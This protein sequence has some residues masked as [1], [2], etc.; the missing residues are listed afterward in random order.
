M[1]L[2]R[3]IFL[4]KSPKES[5]RQVLENLEKRFEH[6]D[7]IAA[8]LLENNIES[9]CDKKKV[10]IQAQ[11]QNAI[12]EKATRQILNKVKQFSDKTKTTQVNNQNGLQNGVDFS[13]LTKFFENFDHKLNILI[14]SIEASYN[15]LSNEIIEKCEFEFI[16]EKLNEQRE[17]LIEKVNRRMSFEINNV[18]SKLKMI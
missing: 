3:R 16:A 18:N 15:A 4:K 8:E 13:D 17:K 6:I 10:K 1:F 11:I 9:T 2:L 7:Q 5:T 14:E 12:R